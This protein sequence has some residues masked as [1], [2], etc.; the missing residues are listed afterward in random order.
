MYEYMQS[1]RYICLLFRASI[2]LASLLFIP[3]CKLRAGRFIV[4]VIPL[5]KK[6]KEGEKRENMIEESEIPDR[7][8]LHRR[9]FLFRQI[10]RVT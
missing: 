4:I 5:K 10:G 3:R 9:F 1:M 8:A 7:T 6:R 2:F